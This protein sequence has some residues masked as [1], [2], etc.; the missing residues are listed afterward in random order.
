[1]S[2]SESS[3]EHTFVPEFGFT[4]AEH[5]PE[6][7]RIVLGQQ[8]RRVTLDDGVNFFEWAAERW[9]APRWTVELDPW[10]LRQ[11][12]RHRMRTATPEGQP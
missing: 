1:M 4:A 6:R 3:W 7:P 10:Q 8:Q 5:D 2:P 12:G 11:P 9:P